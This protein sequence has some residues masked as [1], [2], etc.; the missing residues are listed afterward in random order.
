M[1]LPVE[2]LKKN[3][4]LEM[5][6]QFKP[7]QLE[8][9]NIISQTFRVLRENVKLL[10]LRLQR[11]M[12]VSQ[13]RLF[14]RIEQAETGRKEARKGGGGG[15]REGGRKKEWG[16][17]KRERRKEREK[18]ENKEQ[19]HGEIKTSFLNILNLNK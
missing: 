8:V 15:V 3:G 12:I 6:I 19:S 4:W 1:N 16:R 17:K 11:E 5:G 10:L 9:I 7:N 14:L 13:E 2:L 18:K